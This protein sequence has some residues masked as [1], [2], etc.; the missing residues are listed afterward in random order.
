MT[1][2]YAFSRPREQS[3]D[4]RVVAGAEMQSVA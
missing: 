1:A 2:V 4:L 3:F